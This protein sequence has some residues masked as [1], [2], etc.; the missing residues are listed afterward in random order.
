MMKTKNIGRVW[1]GIFTVLLCLSML[2]MNLTVA[3]VVRADEADASLAKV[4]LVKDTFQT[5]VRSKIEVNAQYGGDI[6]SLEGR[7]YWHLV[8]NGPDRSN[9]SMAFYSEYISNN[10]MLVAFDVF[11]ELDNKPLVFEK[12]G[13]YTMDIS[14][15][16]D[17]PR[18]ETTITTLSFTVKDSSED[19]GDDK[20][21]DKKDD[22]TDDWFKSYDS[23][24]ENGKMPF[25][26][27][28]KGNKTHLDLDTNDSIEISVQLPFKYSIAKK[29]IQKELEMYPNRDSIDDLKPGKA[30]PTTVKVMYQ[31]AGTTKT[32]ELKQELRFGYFDEHVFKFKS[33]ELL[34][35]IQ[36][37]VYG[38]VAYAGIVTIEFKGDGDGR[39][40]QEPFTETVSF[41]VSKKA[42]IK[43][44]QAVTKSTPLAYGEEQAFYV[45]DTLGGNI[46]VTIYKGSKKIRT[47]TGN[48]TLG[49]GEDANAY[50]YAYWDLM[51]SSKK[52]VAPGKYTAKIYTDVKLTL[53]NNGKK[54]T[55]SIKSKTKTVSFNVVKAKGTLK[56]T[57]VPT[58]LNGGEYAT[59]ENPMIGIQNT[60]SIGSKIAVKIKNPKGTVIKNDSYVQSSGT[61]TRWYDL[62]KLDA[63]LSLGKYTATVT[64]QIIGG[65]K[66]TKNISFSVEKSPKVEISNVSLSV[67]NGV[68]N[69]SFVTSQSSKVNVVVKDSKGSIVA[70]V[71]SGQYSAGTIKANFTTGNYTPG[72]YSVEF[73]ATNSGGTSTAAKS[74]TI[75]KKPVV[76]TKPTVSG[77][78]IRYTQKNKEDAYQV[79]LGY[80]GKGAKVVIEIMWNDAEQI[81]KTYQY[82][83]I[84]DSGNVSWIWDGYKSNG[85]RASTGNYTV[86]AYAVNSAGQTEYLRQ[87]FT[88][89]EG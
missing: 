37:Y 13:K 63:N 39:Y 41:S 27:T 30:T 11:D 73:S 75:E 38:D 22:K 77:L 17:S 55:K 88:I 5:G 71:L 20:A 8:V 85:F 16:C 18:Y 80:T 33:D 72:N 1:K 4:S 25:S 68:G 31:P 40:Y 15:C 6:S 64:A 52:Y 19:K 53:L 82:T 3:Q 10:N 12:A 26:A 74:F 84:K 83:T 51:N 89:N 14:I 70:T 28:F 66:V 76:V 49:K 58:G 61:A 46:H 56:L 34:K 44:A 45:E 29:D 81:V 50:G 67:N 7:P 59:Y 60:V 65:K 36:D 78:S 42:A 47:I 48:C 62:A 87:N 9:S 69:V 35:T 54:Q 2:C 86:R 57:S 32:R 23:K 79:S 43:K 24:A 21:D